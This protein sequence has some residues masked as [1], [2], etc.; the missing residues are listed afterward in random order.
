MLKTFV[1]TARAENVLRVVQK[2]TSLMSRKRLK[3][4]DMQIKEASLPGES[5]LVLTLQEDAAQIQWLVKQMRK[6]I[7]LLDLDL[8][9]LEE[10]PKEDAQMYELVF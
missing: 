4:R 2:L 10:E 6:C 1:I 5:Y 3:I 7:D 9:L 8:K